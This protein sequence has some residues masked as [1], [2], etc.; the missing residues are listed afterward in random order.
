MVDKGRPV[1]RH[2]NLLVDNDKRDLSVS[3][4]GSLSAI[5]SGQMAIH[6]ADADPH[7]GYRLESEDHDHSSTGL[8]GGKLDHGLALDGL[9][10]DD[11][12]QYILADGTRD[13]IGVVGGVT[14]TDDAHL[15]TKAYVD[16]SVSV[17]ER[18]S[19]VIMYIPA[20]TGLYYDDTNHDVRIRTSVDSD[21]VNILIP[22]GWR[23]N[24]NSLK[25]EV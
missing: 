23:W 20:S 18:L 4:S 2:P 7:T 25:V 11:H 15:A 14:P 19:N 22:Q 24:S 8:Q 1:Q 10:D 13:F 9:I 5:V 3:S 12:T 6:V 21:T 17:S 16:N